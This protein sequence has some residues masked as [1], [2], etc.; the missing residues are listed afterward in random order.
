L[1]QQVTKNIRLA[2]KADNLERAWAWTKTNSEAMF[3]N[4]FRHI[5]RG[6]SISATEN[7]ADLRRRLTQGTYKPSHAMKLY[8]P[9]QSGILRPYSRLCVEDQIVYQAMVNIVAEKLR[10]RVIR[11][12]YKSVFGHLYAGKRSLFFYRKWQTGYR[13]FSDALRHTPCTCS[14]AHPMSTNSPKTGD[15][16]EPLP[17]PGKGACSGK[18]GLTGCK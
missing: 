16:L 8:L 5:Y 15:A 4:Y 11:R 7:L 14:N 10:P 1:G 9:K 12:Y 13:K 6:Y 3:K 18:G 2:F 17:F